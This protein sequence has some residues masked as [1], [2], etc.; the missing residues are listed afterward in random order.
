MDKFTANYCYSNSNFIISNLPNIQKVTP[1]TNI[2]R[3]V[4]NLV[5]RG[6]PTIASQFLR[7]ELGLE[8]NYLNSIKQVKFLSQ[9]KLN[10]TQTIKGDVSNDDYPAD[11]FYD[12]LDYILN[13]ISF[14]RNLTVAEYPISEIIPDIKQAF[15]KQMVD[16]Y[17]PLIKTVIEVDGSGHKRQAVLDRKRDSAFNR[18]GIKVV[19]ID[20]SKIRNKDY[21]QFKNEFRDIYRQYKDAIEDYY[22]YLDINPSE[23]D[24]QIKLTTIARLQV[25]VLELIDR[26]VLS[27]N[28]KNWNFNLANN[29][30]GFCLELALKDLQIWIGHIA[31]L[32]NMNIDMP[33]IRINILESNSELI[34]N[35]KGINIDFDLY[36]R[37]DDSIKQANVYHIRTDFV[38][39]AN[40]FSVKV[41]EPVVY[42]LKAEIHKQS[43]GFLLENLFGF[44]S[45][46]EGQL[47]I[48]INSLNGEDTVGLLPTGGGKSLTYQL[49]V[50]L[51]PAIS[52]VVVPIKSLMFDQINNINNKNHITHA[53]F[54]NG[55]L[56]PDEADKRLRDF[57][58]GKYFFLIISP[59]RFQSKKFREE[60]SLVNVSKALS[61]AVI[62][63]VHCLS[64]WGHD[65]RTS[66]L[67][68]AN[69]IRKYAPST[70]FLA[71]TATASSK[72]LR[73][74]MT[75]LE[76]DSANVITI[77]N[78]TRKELTFNILKV[79]K[80]SKKN[81]LIEYIKSVSG[82][83]NKENPKG[84]SIVFTQTV[85]GPSGCYEL[86]HF[87]NSSTGFQTGFYSGSSPKA[88]NNDTFSK[89]KDEIQ[90][91]FMKD[92]IDVLVATKAFGMGIDKGNIRNTI[93]YGI[94][95]SL[96]S[97]YQEAGRAG[98][99][100]NNSN[101][102]VL[103]SPDQLDKEQQ[104]NIFGMN[105]SVA[106]LEKEK[107][108]VT[109]DLNTLL[110]FLSTNL[111]NIEDEVE[112]IYK[113]YL[114]HI[115]TKEETTI[116]LDYHND[117]DREL[118][119]KSIYRLALL[120]V[121][122]DWTLDWKSRQV[123]VEV[124]DWSEDT[125]IN[126]L[127]SHIQKYDYM[128]TLKKSEK[129]PDQYTEII[130]HFYKDNDP[131]LK[132]ILFVLL[133]W[134]NDNV[135]YSRK[136]SLLL[137]KEYADDFTDSESLQ[138]KIEVYF[139][140]NDDVYLL[141]QIVAQ[142]DRLRDWMKIFYV[143]EE[144][145]VDQPRA[146][147]TFKSL[148]ITVSRFLESYNNDISLNLI[149]GLI[150]LVEGQFESIDGRER[151][152]LAVRE[153]SQMETEL[154]EEMLVS[155]L[156]TSDVFLNSEQ[157]S[158]LSEV[159][160]SNGFDLMED[161]KLIYSSLEDRFSYGSM[162]KTL[163]STIK[164]KSYGGYPWEK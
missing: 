6:N 43:L 89:Y 96:E 72:V 56:T 2:I 63:E 22:S 66:Y 135:I 50:M 151:M 105:T 125:V 71:L 38:D 65:F 115:D 42:S 52:F 48:I 143:Q 39:K 59:E 118:Y 60:L 150:N 31:A 23:F 49:C 112:Q 41:N 35:D 104:Q 54:I 29:N 10:W 142:K 147:S 148:K 20:T 36:K 58:N 98:R 113:F 139:K 51:Q 21:E 40:Y 53:S 127:T 37:W 88:W 110:F 152:S 156:N 75:E 116:L 1:Y 106:L 7:D 92:E 141:E 134:Y 26:D 17:I 64:E 57:A 136:R 46:N 90:Q 44:K 155:V 8:R 87:I 5:T 123:E 82:E 109:G 67:A 94:P 76:I 117:R 45:F 99:D 47:E 162:I 24:T 111:K 91:S 133:K 158:D 161:L 33:H 149:N 86:S 78:F 153:V 79:N 164:E 160:I 62:D 124:A 70:R 18:A 107:R 140:R 93:H 163:H 145:K 19:R 130:E 32:F 132:K 69:T 85:N 137:M 14:I 129:M 97:F 13:R 157:K 61:Y 27:F 121:V 73:D 154:R 146:L 77:S 25:L 100:R 102:V 68:L 138:R 126:K 122:E 16:F 159:L 81:S 108:K 4:Q 30:I 34:A 3:I 28:S 103:Y 74:I 128:F 101:C 11:Q 144:G 84:A 120:G 95:N 80:A 55:D 119:E 15:N 9:D 131:F 83:Q 12:D 114:S